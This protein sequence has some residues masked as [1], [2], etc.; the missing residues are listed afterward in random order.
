MHINL[1]IV[2]MHSMAS[3]QKQGNRGQLFSGDIAVATVVFILALSLTFFLWN[4]T[5]D[6]INSAERLR[7]L[8]KMAASTT[9]QLLRTP[10]I[11]ADW[12][13]QWD[14]Q[15]A[16]TRSG[17]P[18]IATVDRVIN[19]T[20][21][22]AFVDLMNSTYYEDYKH[23]MGLG[24][25]DFYMNVTN[26]TNAQV[27]INEKPFV[28]GKPIVDSEESVAVLRT[29]IFNGEIVRVNFVIWK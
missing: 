6:D 12:D 23:L 19:A 9:E 10:G 8:Q 22:E 18:G 20:K 26:L 29:A 7:D 17:V 24:E 3:I 15:G 5:T 2:N 16:G 1:R 11:P 14:L 28:A 21:A 25:F 27:Y 13:T 4:S